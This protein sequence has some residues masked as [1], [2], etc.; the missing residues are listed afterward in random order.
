MKENKANS[1][2]RNEKINIVLD[3]IAKKRTLKVNNFCAQN[4]GLD[5]KSNSEYDLITDT[6]TTENLA[7]KLDGTSSHCVITPKGNEVSETGG[8]LIYLK[9]KQE[10]E[11]LNTKNTQLGITSAESNL[12]A[13]R[14]NK[15]DSQFNRWAFGFNIL[16]GLINIGLLLW[17]LLN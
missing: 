6:L 1:L 12:E 9:Q 17:S 5:E 2:T 11:L 16:F 10:K 14:I 15:R 8:W 7:R 13:N 3:T 4:W